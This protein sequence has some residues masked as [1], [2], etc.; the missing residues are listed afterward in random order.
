[1]ISAS[2][3]SDHGWSDLSVVVEGDA[4][5][6]TLHFGTDWQTG[7]K[8]KWLKAIKELQVKNEPYFPAETGCAVSVTF[9]QIL[10]IIDGLY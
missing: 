8:N 2:E 4:L 9:W 7:L 3:G 6:S 5:S 10:W 1:M